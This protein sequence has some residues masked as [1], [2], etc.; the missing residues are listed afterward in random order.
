MR[1]HVTHITKEDFFPTFYAAYQAAMMEKTIQGGFQGS[2]LVPFNPESV[3]SK[4]DLKFKTPTPPNSRPCTAQSWVS[5]TPSNPTE[6]SLQT[7]FIKSRIARH[8][9]SSPTSI[10]EAVDQFAKATSKVMS[11]LALLKSENQILQQTNEELSKR[12]RA[13]K[14]RLR[15]GGSLSLQEA[16][17][18]QDQKDVAQQVRQELQAGSGRKARAE[19]RARRCGNCGE[20][21]HNARTCQNDIET[22]KEEDSKQF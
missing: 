18:L 20:I 2:R 9:N 14:T 10:Y 6:A 7:S 4:L 15:Q 3:I 16:Q 17:D 13:K 12:R 8:E 11:K 5:K 21:G 1:A 19:T 22:S